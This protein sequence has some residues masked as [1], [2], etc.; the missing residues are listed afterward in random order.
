MVQIAEQTG[1]V[2]DE[3]KQELVER[4]DC[5]TGDVCFY[6]GP[7]GTGDMC[8]W[9]GNDDDWQRGSVT[10]SWSARTTVKS[11]KNN[12]TSTAYNGVRYYDQVGQDR[13]DSVGCIPRGG[14][15]TLRNER[16]LKS[17]KWETGACG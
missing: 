8:H 13:D 2:W 3:Q 11:V 15:G 5:N 9:S 14:R 7:A 10:C 4:W 17:H 16:F 12:G 6:S 1:R